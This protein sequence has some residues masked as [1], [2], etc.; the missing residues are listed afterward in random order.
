MT[1]SCAEPGNPNVARLNLTKP[2]SGWLKTATLV[3]GLNKL[4]QGDFIWRIAR[5]MSVVSDCLYYFQNYYLHQTN[6]TAINVPDPVPDI[7]HPY[8]WVR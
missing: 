1:A 8:R 3:R 4:I 6:A 2:Y 7:S 5:L